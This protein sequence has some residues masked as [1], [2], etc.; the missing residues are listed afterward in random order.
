VSIAALNV[1]TIALFIGAKLAA[2]LVSIQRR[3][4]LGRAKVIMTT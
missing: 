3:T 4:S 2:A 1:E